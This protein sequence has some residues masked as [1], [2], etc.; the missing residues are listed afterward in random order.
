MSPF[1]VIPS[2]WKTLNRCGVRKQKQNHL[3]LNHFSAKK[4]SIQR[5]VC[6][7]SEDIRTRRACAASVRNDSAS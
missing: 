7:G 2:S 5:S 3:I 4:S 1:L 6:E